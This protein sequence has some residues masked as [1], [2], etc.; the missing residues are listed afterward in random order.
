M[1]PSMRVPLF[2]NPKYKR[3]TLRFYSKPKSVV[4]EKMAEKLIDKWFLSTY[5][6]TFQFGL[7]YTIKFM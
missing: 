4:R 1:L 5:F 7:L 6:L 2:P 3:K